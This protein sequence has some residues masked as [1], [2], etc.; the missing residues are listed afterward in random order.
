[1]TLLDENVI[2]LDGSKKIISGKASDTINKDTL[3]NLYD[4]DMEVEYLEKHNRKI[5]FFENIKIKKMGDK[6]EKV[7]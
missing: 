7:I 2:I 1:M 3:H 5:C 6:N 4:V